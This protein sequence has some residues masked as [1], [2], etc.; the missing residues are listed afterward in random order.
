MLIYFLRGW[1]SRAMESLGCGPIDIKR[2]IARN[3]YVNIITTITPFPMHTPI[4]CTMK[5]II[6]KQF[7]LKRTYGTHSNI[8]H[9]T[10]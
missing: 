3:L 10:N 9:N 8:R 7:M 2:M 1:L 4:P 5:R 6:H